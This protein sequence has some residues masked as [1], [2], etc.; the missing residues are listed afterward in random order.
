LFWG[1]IDGI[2]KDY[3]I[4]LGINYRGVYDFPAK[5][6]Y[7][8]S[9]DFKFAPLPEIEAEYKDKFVSFRAPFSGKHEDILIKS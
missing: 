3:Y 8:S 4:A 6:F 1:K 7:Y 2:E 9:I 5:T